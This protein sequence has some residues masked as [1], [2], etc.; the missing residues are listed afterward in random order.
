MVVM[1]RNVAVT[2]PKRLRTTERLAAAAIRL[3]AVTVKASDP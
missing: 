1:H 2:T 3:Q